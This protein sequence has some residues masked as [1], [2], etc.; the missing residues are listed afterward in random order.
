[1][2]FER[3]TFEETKS[4]IQN[5]LNHSSSSDFDLTPNGI[6][7]LAQESNC[8]LQRKSIPNWSDFEVGI[9]DFSVQQF[10]ALTPINLETTDSVFII[11]D[12]C[13]K[14]QMSYKIQGK[15]LIEF[16][17]STYPNLHQMDFVQ[18]L[19]FIFI[20]PNENLISI[21]HHEGV[22]LE[23]HNRPTYER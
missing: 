10:I 23:Y 21:I 3:I 11:S 14:E 15:K 12:T 5:I 18:P 17:E 19:D 8:F 16:A 7:K 13:F 9:S 6:F 22:I 4:I 1:M 2:N 20:Q